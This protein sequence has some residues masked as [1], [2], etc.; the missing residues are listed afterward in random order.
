MATATFMAAFRKDAVESDVFSEADAVT[1]KFEV[2]GATNYS[3]A[4]YLK[5]N[6]KNIEGV[7][8]NGLNLRGMNNPEDTGEVKAF[9][10]TTTDS[11][12]NNTFIQ[13]MNATTHK[14]I[15]IFSGRNLR[16][17]PAIDAWFSAAGSVNWPGQFLCNNYSAGYVGF[18]SPSLKKIVGEVM[19]STDGIDKG[20]ANYTTVYDTFA[21]I[22]ALGFP[23]RIVYDQQTYAA[24]TGYE[25]KRFPTANT[26]NKLSDYGLKVG[27]VVILQADLVHS[28]Q[29]QS[30]GMKTRMDIRWL[31]GSTLLDASASIESSSV[32]WANKT[33]Y[34]TVPAGADGF[35]IV[36]SRYPRNDTLSG[37]SMV[38]NVVFSEVTRDG[39]KQ[40][41]NAMIGV[42]GIKAGE[43]VEKQT[44]VRL[45]D[46]DIRVSTLTNIVPVVGIYEG[47]SSGPPPAP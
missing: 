29:M 15:V 34:S 10:L 3:G 17:S 26:Y 43:F 5:R 36:V 32:N 21:D 18:Y 23:T 33:V 4:P 46:M 11:T 40:S 24:T 1:Y 19:I 20:Y 37:T 44:G 31:K 2:G 41:T 22:G 47:D 7:T 38:R 6:G 45:M 39:S 8:S 25:Y 42:N 28:S 16:S 35:T 12:L 27:S 13:Y 9:E 14:I 30:A